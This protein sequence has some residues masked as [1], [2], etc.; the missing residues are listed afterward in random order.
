MEDEQNGRQSKWKTIKMKD[1]QN[2][3]QPK[4]KMT[5]ME[6]VQNRNKTSTLQNQSKI[7][8]SI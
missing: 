7:N 8:Q 3:R 1:D 5:Q 4:C 2:G 6:D